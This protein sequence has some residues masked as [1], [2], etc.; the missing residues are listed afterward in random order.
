M[1]YEAVVVG[2][3]A[4]GLFAL[5]M[6]LEKLPAGYPI[7]V[8]IIQHR[9]KEEK[10]LLE[11]VLQAKCG[12]RIKQADEKE[13]VT[14]GTVY[15]GPADYHLLIERDRCFSLS[16]EGPVNFSRPSIDI[17]FETASEVYKD[18]VVGIILTGASNDGA[19]GIQA[20]RRQGGIT[21]A[22]DPVEAQFPYM[23]G[24]AIGTGSVLHIFKLE[25]IKDYL[26]TI[27]KPIV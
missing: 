15:L 12:V 5:S 6:I 17:L 22:Q 2:V 7:P 16:C 19:A 27:G 4:G 21:I 18:K 26:L 8:I 20:I 14:G 3:S 9:S 11:E 10:T 24:A 1:K 25:L 23:P 13:P